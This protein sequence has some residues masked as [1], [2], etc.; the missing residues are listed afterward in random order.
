MFMREY[1]KRFK[2]IFL[3]LMVVVQVGLYIVPYQSVT[4]ATSRQMERLGRGVVAVKVSNGVFV[5]WRLF[6]TDP[7]SRDFNV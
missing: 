3:L 5:S 7:D 2:K 1:T 6:G 4:A